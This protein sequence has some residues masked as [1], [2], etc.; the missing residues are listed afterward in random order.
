[1]PVY[2]YNCS[3]CS[4]EQEVFRPVSQHTKT[5]PC[6]CGAEARQKITP[7]HVIPD[8]QPYRSIM[9]GE[10]IRGR[11]HHREHLKQHGVI[12]VGNE[13]VE[14]KVKELPPVVPDIKRAI[15]EVRSR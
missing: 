8:I 6:D 13:K 10:R 7:L 2:I 12:E 15:D 5:I 4:T 9:T 3:N 11:A 14:R 1:M